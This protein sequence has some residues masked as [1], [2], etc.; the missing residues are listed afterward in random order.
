MQHCHFD[1]RGD[2]RSP[3]SD[4]RARYRPVQTGW[5]HLAARAR[6]RWAGCLARAESLKCRT[7]AASGPDPKWRLPRQTSG[8]S[9]QR[10][11]PSEFSNPRERVEFAGFPTVN[12]GSLPTIEFLLVWLEAPMSHLLVGGQLF[13]EFSERDVA[14]EVGIA[15]DARSR[16]R[17]RPGIERGRITVVSNTK[18]LNTRLRTGDD[19]ATSTDSNTRNCKR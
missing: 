17:R 1:E 18:D 5:S 13:D 16:T 4:P 12:H 11:F 19:T 15:D 2:S 9:S 7:Q 8:R 6:H 14:I 10:E 3:P